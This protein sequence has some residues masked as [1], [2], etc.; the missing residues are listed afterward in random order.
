MRF[1]NDK[2]MEDLKID[3]MSKSSS[4][5]IENH[6]S[7]VQQK[8]NLNKAILDQGWGKLKQFIDYKLVW[9]NNHNSIK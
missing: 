4:G 9:K 3:K 6:G 7:N 1:N 5:T 2:I 8:S